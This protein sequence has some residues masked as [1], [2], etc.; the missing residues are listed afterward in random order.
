[1]AEEHVLPVLM[2]VSDHQKNVS[3]QRLQD[4]SSD[5]QAPEVSLERVSGVLAPGRKIGSVVGTLTALGHRPIMDMSIPPG[6]LCRT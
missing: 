1:M 4:I 2:V 5:L 6:P 3:L